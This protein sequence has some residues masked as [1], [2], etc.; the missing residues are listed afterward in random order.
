V[1]KCRSLQF[2]YPSG[3]SGGGHSID[4]NEESGKLYHDLKRVS[5][6]GGGGLVVE[7]DC[8]MTGEGGEKKFE[9]G[10]VRKGGRPPSA[11]A[12]E[13]LY[14]LGVKEPEVW[15]SKAMSKGKLQGGKKGSRGANPC[16]K[17]RRGLTKRTEDRSKGSEEGS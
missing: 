13:R 6:G 1:R 15:E 2:L 4:R 7:I 9:V 16:L 5:P 3:S 10:G 12:E 8:L 17:G 14:T 11:R